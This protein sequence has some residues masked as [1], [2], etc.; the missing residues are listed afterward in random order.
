MSNVA[1][2]GWYLEN[3]NGNHFKFYTVILAG[4]VLVFHWGRIGTSGQAKISVLPEPQARRDAL[5]QV[6][7]KMSGGY[8]VLHEDVSFTLDER[9][10]TRAVERPDPKSLTLM[11]DRALRDPAFA[12]DSVVEAYDAFLAKAER[13]MSSAASPNSKFETVWNDHEDMKKAWAEIE[14]KHSLAQTTLNMVTGMLSQ[15]LMSGSLS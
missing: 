7:S 12:G 9:D 10:I 2:R 5:R 1:S 8:E 13:L 3:H 11:F 6:A 4:E 15:A 14:D